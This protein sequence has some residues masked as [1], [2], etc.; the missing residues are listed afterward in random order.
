MIG[1][2]SFDMM[3]AVNAGARG[4]GVDWG[5]HHRD[6]LIDAGAVAV[7]EH[8]RDVLDYIEGNGR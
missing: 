5:Y 2:T 3:M 1:D 4:I 7:A 6:E 8:P